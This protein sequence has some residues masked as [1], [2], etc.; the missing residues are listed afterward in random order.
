MGNQYFRFKQFLINQDQCA[1]KVGTDSVLLATLT[2]VQ[3]A[4]KALDIGTGTGILSLMIAQQNPKL[5]I[6]AIEIDSLAYQQAQSNFENSPFKEQ[7]QVHLGAFQQFFTTQKYD[8]IITNP[9]YFIGKNNFS[10]AD[11]QRAKARHDNDL[12]FADLID[13]TISLLANDGIFCLILPTS[14]SLIF[15]NLALSKGMFCSHTTYIKPKA[16]KAANRVIL[17][18]VTY[19]TTEIVSEFIIYNDNNLATNEFKHLTEDYYL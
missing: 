3:Q 16:S 2:P 12:P 14:E 11:Q 9:P 17:N 4:K 18:F 13:K 7:I 15:K 1:M 5:T 19:Q 10:I 6:D 8:I